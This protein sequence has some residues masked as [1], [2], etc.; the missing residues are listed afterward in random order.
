MRYSILIL[1]TI[2]IFLIGCSGKSSSSNPLLPQ[3]ANSGLSSAQSPGPSHVL[4]GIYN[5]VVEPDG[6]GQALINIV[7]LR[8]AMFNANVQKFLSP[9]VSATNLITIKMLSGS[10]FANGY[11]NLDIGIRHPFPGSAQFRGFDVLGIFMADASQASEYDPALIFAPP[12]TGGGPSDAAY[13]LNPDGY[14]RWFNATEFTDSLPLFSFK[15]GKL[16]NDSFPSATLNP[17]K[18]FA[19]ELVLDSD[20]SSLLPENRGTFSPSGNINHRNYHI[21]FPVPGAPQYKFSYAVDASWEQPDPA[22]A[23]SYPIESFP[24]SAQMQEPYN[25]SISDSGTDAYY[26]NGLSGGTVK[27][28]IEIFDWL[29]LTNAQGVP[30]QIS[31]IRL[32]GSPFVSPIDILPLATVSTGT[33]ATS[34]VF[35]VELQSGQLSIASSGEFACLCTVESSNPT[36][37]KPQIANGDSIIYPHD[38][39]LSSFSFAEIH[40]GD[41][42]PNTLTLTSPNGGESWKVASSHDITWTAQGTIDFVTL[43]YSKDDFV[44]DINPIASNVINGGYYLWDVIPDDPSE[45]V[46]VRVSW[47]SNPSVFDISDNNFSITS[48]PK[49]PHLI[50]TLEGFHSPYYCRVDTQNNEAWVDCTQSAPIKDFGFYRIDNSENVEKVFDKEGG[51]GG[52]NGMPGPFGLNVEARK[53]I[54]PD[55]F[56][57]YTPD[58]IDVWDLD[59]GASLKFFIPFEPGYDEIFLGGDGEL[60]QD[61]SVACATDTATKPNGRLITWDYNAADPVY[62]THWTSEFPSMIEPDYQGHRLFILT[63]GDFGGSGPAVEVWNVE[64]WTII[65][66]F[67]TDVAVWPFMTDTRF[68]PAL[69]R[70]YFGIS[71]SM[72]EVWDMSNYSHI[73]TID[74]TLGAV[75]GIDHMAGSI[76]VTVP[77]HLLV[78]DEQTFEL[79]WNVDCGTDP[80]CLSCNP[81]TGKIYV[82]DMDAGTVLVFQG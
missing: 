62:T 52:F 38:A 44:S 29:S 4:W 25:I 51:G 1:C 10:N 2:L 57:M 54:A 58:P 31:A 42:S 53:I 70:L 19:D 81:D 43:E 12:V 18:Y 21:Q 17:Y 66:K 59:G 45:T 48:E 73:Q 69:N 28:D 74:T 75:Q 40:I 47:A 39:V 23:P 24:P 61:L 82:P 56:S 13:M 20:V 16:G 76:Y 15:P 71:T 14:T 5:V 46:K 64:D 30:G 11:L 7:P 41:K 36:T 65:T 72:F 32:E 63:R 49:P 34:S 9:P 22:F 60:F 3:T 27:L 67:Q 68:D 50:A 6:A 37:Y 77:G 80:R 79:I 26:E 55:L 78:Y 8:G 33:A 35:S